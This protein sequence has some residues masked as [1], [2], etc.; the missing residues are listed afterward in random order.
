MSHFLATA[1]LPAAL[2]MQAPHRRSTTR[3]MRC[4]ICPPPP[5][6][7]RTQQAWADWAIDEMRQLVLASKGGAFL[8][9]TSYRMMEEATAHRPIFTL[10][11]LTVLVQGD[12]PK[13]EIARRFRDD[14]NAVLFATKS[15]FEGVSI[16]G[17]AAAGGRG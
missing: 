3:P 1:G 13:M 14:G 17:G 11:G 10:R 9:F 15:F 8:L 6:L 2:E 7:H 16:D 12:M 5:R 4:C